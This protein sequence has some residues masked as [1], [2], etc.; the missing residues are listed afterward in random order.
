MLLKEKGAAKLTCLTISDMHCAGCVASVEKALNGLA[1][2]ESAEV[3]FAN[4]SAQVIS[5]VDVSALIA[6]IKTAGFTAEVD[7]SSSLKEQDLA[8]SEQWAIEY[9]AA[10]KRAL[11]AASLGAPLMLASWLNVLPR[12]GE[13]SFTAV[14]ILIA[15]L[16]L[17]AMVYSGRSYYLG[18]WQ[19]LK[20]GRA[21]M[22]SLVA[23]GTSAAWIYSLAVVIFPNID[24]TKAGHAYFESAMLILAFLNLG[25]ALEARA[26][27]KTADAISK[28]I[29]LQPPNACLIKQGVEIIVAVDDV[30]VGDVLRIKPGD[31]IPV[32]GVVVSGQSAVDQS[33]I[34]GEPIPVEKAKDDEV[35]AG[36]INTNG[37]L[38]VRATRSVKESL[39]SSIV[40]YVRKAQN[41][42]PDIARLVDKIA[43]IFVP[44]VLLIAILNATLWLIFGSGLAYAYAFETTLS[45]LIIACPC[46]LGLATPISLIIGMGKA[47]ESGVLIRDGQV[48]NLAHKI[49]TVVF[50]KTGTLTEGKP[51]LVSTINVSDKPDE[52]LLAIAASLEQ[53]SE[54][55]LAQAVHEHAIERQV[56][57]KSVDNFNSVPGRGVIADIGN[58]KLMLGNS[59]LMQES[60]VNTDRVDNE[61]RQQGNQA[62]SIIYVAEDNILLGAFIFKD[63]LKKDSKAVC[64][65]LKALGNKLVILSG[66]NLPAAQAVANELGVDEVFAELL[67]EQKAEKI[68]QF[69]ES[70][71]IVEMV[72]DGINDAPALVNAD[73][74]IAVGKGTDIAIESSAVTLLSPSLQG[75]A[76]LQKVSKL[77]L[78]NIKQNLFWAFMYNTL[79]IPVAAGA[80]LLIGGPLL[81]P[82]F[83]GAAMALSSLTV[84]LNAS[85]LRRMRL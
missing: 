8:Q 82:M 12:P 73:V 9:S 50:D 49:D 23:L 66:D 77:T 67:P 36:S 7:Q 15:V 84:V 38:D 59:R 18:A 57:I 25:N 41:S 17:L 29:Q 61:L 3:D 35:L 39:L 10:L 24:P 37:S 21:N 69:K 56:E 2:I 43:S 51:K 76:V 60:K 63:P 13:T 48:M 14:G 62:A 64:Q 71:Q 1:G 47:A 5:D 11:L 26:R 32:D 44:I 78:R 79:S 34:N 20:R 53:Y 80:L 31:Q 74:G 52:R 19:Q 75:V 40:E 58:S 54:H 22:D 6:A 65:Q 85:R 33:M 68:T 81:S 55:P 30:C 45:V 42:K 70:G 46:A 16:A 28:L 4:K 72:G 27:G 83:A